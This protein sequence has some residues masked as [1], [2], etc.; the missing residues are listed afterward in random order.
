MRHTF[1]AV[2]D[3]LPFA[4]DAIPD[5]IGKIVNIAVRISVTPRA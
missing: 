3:K 2:V 5:D 4:G 1:F